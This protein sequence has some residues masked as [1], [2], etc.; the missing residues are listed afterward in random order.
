VFVPLDFGGKNAADGLAVLTDFVI[1]RP[2][3]AVD[4]LWA[5]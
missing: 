3:L 2:A 4:E 5:F 1:I